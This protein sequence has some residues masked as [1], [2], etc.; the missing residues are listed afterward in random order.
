MLCVEGTQNYLLVISYGSHMAFTQQLANNGFLW[1][2]QILIQST[3]DLAQIH[4]SL[5]NDFLCR[6]RVGIHFIIIFRLGI[7]DWDGSALP[8]CAFHEIRALG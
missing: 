2:T 6:L 5:D 3:Q 8:D 4:F 1:K 7:W